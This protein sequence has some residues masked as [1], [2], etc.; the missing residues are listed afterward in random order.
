[1]I[2]V[3]PNL[4]TKIKL[5]VVVV[6]AIIKL[7]QKTILGSPIPVNIAVA[8]H[9]NIDM[10]YGM[11]KNLNTKAASSNPGPSQTKIIRSAKTEVNK[12]AGVDITVRYL[13]EVWKTSLNFSTPKLA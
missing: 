13:R 3:R 1:M 10:K 11:D 9:D 2:P 5:S 7:L 8:G 12:K 6:T 4:T